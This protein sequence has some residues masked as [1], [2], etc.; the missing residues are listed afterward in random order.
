MRKKQNKI[1][2][3]FN[4]S[5]PNHVFRHYREYHDDKVDKEQHMHVLRQQHHAHALFTCRGTLNNGGRCDFEES[6]Q[7][8]KAL[9]FHQKYVNL[10]SEDK[11]RSCRFGTT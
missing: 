5:S 6:M 10:C 2:T 11:Q 7:G 8:Q 1:V 3:L 4:N 9:G